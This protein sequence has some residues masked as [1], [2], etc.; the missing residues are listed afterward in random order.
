MSDDAG[1]LRVTVETA[2]RVDRTLARRFPDAGRRELAALFEAGAVRIGRR[3]ARKGD[4]VVPGDVIELARAPAGRDELRPAPDPDALARIAVIVERADLVAIAKPAGMPSQPLRAGERGTAA[5]AIAARWPECAA[6]VPDALDVRDGGLVHRLDIGTSGVLVAARDATTYRALREAFGAGAIAKRYVAITD[7]RPVARE[8]ESP[9]AQRGP[10]A[11]VDHTDGL[12]AH[13]TFEVLDA[14]AAHAVVRCV[15]RTGRMHQ[16][17][18][19]LAE[20]GAPITGDAR[21]G[22]A[23]LPGHD[24]FFLHAAALVLPDGARLIAPLPDRFV[25]AL[26]ACGL[27][28]PDLGDPRT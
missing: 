8:C 15:A 18:A 1:A 11:V 23:P 27:R 19:H 22:G 6:A 14:T 4:R 12:A 2:D 28:A 5:N 26:A 3:R 7:G 21:Y 17:R 24:G 25:A 13:T 10:R 16:V 20:V 9:L